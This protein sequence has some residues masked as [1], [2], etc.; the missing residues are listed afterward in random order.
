[1]GD[2]SSGKAKVDNQLSV[3]VGGK[4]INKNPYCYRCYTKGHTLQECT[5]KFYC[6][7]C[8]SEDHIGSR[9]PIFRSNNKPSAEL[10]GYAVDGLGFFHIPLSVGQ[11]I[12]HDSK[13]ALVKVTRGQMTVQNVV[14][15][16]ER[17]IPGNWKWVVEDNGDNTFRTIFPSAAE[18]KRMVE[19]GTVHTK[20][21]DAEMK[22][23]ERGV[24]NEVKYVLPKVW[25]Q[26]KGLPSE[27]REFL[28]IW[29][30]GSI[31][32]ITKMVD[33][34]FTRRYGIARL[35]VLVLDPSLIPDVVD[36]AIGDNLY[37]L[38]FKVEQE[39]GFDVPEPIGMDNSGDR[40]EGK[41]MDGSDVQDKGKGSDGS[42]F[43]DGSRLQGG[44]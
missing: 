10:C 17:L 39:N 12:K 20:V 34:N 23:I 13:A 9:C 25:V 28:I 43:K 6:E 5:S 29:A 22:I 38:C 40:E 37:E 7:V 3:H 32:G 31:L 16:L 4:G 41:N 26:C 2:K 8:E 27:L 30:V 19:W 33:M 14:S 24:G 36:V 42:N 44:G 11:R 15:E 35:Q 1:M 18:L 21:S